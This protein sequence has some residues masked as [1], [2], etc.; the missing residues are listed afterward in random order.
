LI[1]KVLKPFLYLNCSLMRA[2]PNND[3]IVE[4]TE[5]Q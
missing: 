2:E 1:I 3:L 5:E 4:N